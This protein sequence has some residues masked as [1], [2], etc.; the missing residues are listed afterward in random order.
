MQPSTIAKW[1]CG[2][3]QASDDAEGCCPSILAKA[4][5]TATASA[6]KTPVP[7]ARCCVPWF[8]V[9]ARES[10]APMLE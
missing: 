4:S 10:P 2:E 7:V 5:Q 6:T 3:S 9:S 1:A 8:V